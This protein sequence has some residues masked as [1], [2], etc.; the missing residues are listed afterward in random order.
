M[1]FLLPL[2][3]CVLFACTLTA[4]STISA[5]KLIDQINSGADIALT[6]ATITGDLDFTRINDRKQEN[7][8]S[9]GS[10]ESYRYHVRVGLS[11]VNCTFEGNVVGYRNEGEGKMSSNGPL[12]NADFH[13]DVLFRDCMFKESVNFKYTTFHQDADFPGAKFEEKAGFKYTEFNEA[14]DFNGIQADASVDFKYTEFDEEVSMA[15]ARF[16]EDADFKYTKFPRGAD[17]SNVTFEGDADF[18]YAEFPRGVNMAYTTFRDDAD[19]KYTKFRS[20]ANF[21]GTDFGR[22]ADF[23]YTELDGDR[24]RGGR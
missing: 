18:K 7:S 9:W 10:T 17:L 14:A 19:F 13:K 15:D 12:H 16:G 4:Q 6:N 22:D 8:G 21:E 5:A 11:F 23:K 2:L 1:R 3:P 24:F 20:P